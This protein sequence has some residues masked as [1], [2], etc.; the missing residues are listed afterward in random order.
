MSIEADSGPRRIHA[1]GIAIEGFGVA[2]VGKSGA[3]K[4]DLALRLIDRGAVLVCDDAVELF[5]QDETLWIGLCPNIDGKIE[6]RGL[7]IIA[8][9]YVEKVPLRLVVDLD[10]QPERYPE[11]WPVHSLGGFSVPALHLDGFEASA[12]VKVELALQRLLDQQIK[13]VRQ[14]GSTS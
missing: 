10:T 6:V 13:P 4:S 11:P 3:G 8:T 9:P 12:P 14:A 1:T 5:G 2:L 7:G